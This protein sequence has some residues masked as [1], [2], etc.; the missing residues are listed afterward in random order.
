MA[1]EAKPEIGISKGLA[2]TIMLVIAVVG[3]GAFWSDRGGAEAKA[4]ANHYSIV[5]SHETRLT[6][7]E[8]G[9]TGII[10]RQTSIEKTQISLTKDQEA[11]LIG[12]REMKSQR[13]EDM[14]LLREQR[15]EDAK[16]LREQRSEDM[17]FRAAQQKTI[18][19]LNA[20][21]RTIEKID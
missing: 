7:V 21:L 1:K 9:L 2:A 10:E 6:K 15:S 8:S 13:S 17:K 20:Y 19:E 4:E 11:I 16:L 5:G 12:Q 18:S 3:F 14:K